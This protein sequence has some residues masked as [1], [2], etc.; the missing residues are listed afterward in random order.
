LFNWAQIL[1]NC[2]FFSQYTPILAPV[3]CY[4]AREAQHP[5]AGKVICAPSQTFENARVTVLICRHAFGTVRITGA[6]RFPR[7]VASELPIESPSALNP[8]VQGVLNKSIWGNC[9]F[10]LIAVLVVALLAVILGFTHVAIA[11]V[12]IA[13]VLLFLFVLLFL[14]AVLGHVFRRP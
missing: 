4:L 1:H 5:P 14:V 13:K 11:S 12:G 10:W 9:L 3:L 6:I 7:G 8:A 2:P